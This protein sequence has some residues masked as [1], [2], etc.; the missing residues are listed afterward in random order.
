MVVPV[1]NV[2][3]YLSACVDSLLSQTYEIIE[4][5]LVN[6]GSTDESSEI[7]DAY[8]RSSQRI[9]AVH[10]ENGG[11]SAARNTG[12][13]RATGDYV[14]F[15]DSD[16]WIEADAVRSLLATAQVENADVVVCGFH[17]DVH[18][19]NG[20]LVASTPRLPKPLTV[21]GPLE[22]LSRANRELVGFAGYAWNKLYRR[23]LIEGSTFPEGISLVEDIVFNGPVLARARRVLFI[24]E[25]FVHYVQRPRVT[26]GTGFQPQFGSL[27]ASAGDSVR[28]LLASWGIRGEQADRVVLEVSHGRIQ[29]ALRGLVVNGAVEARIRRAQ[30]KVILKDH[31]VQ[32]ALTAAIGAGIPT[33]VMRP[34]VWSQTRGL[35]W[36][37]YLV[38][39]LRRR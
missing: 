20:E 21:D 2:A 31:L 26:L 6:D 30:M 7:C 12:L 27:V 15:L 39:A 38:H 9:T 33:R 4:I 23:D 22:D 10:R 3:Q 16:D 25:H 37:T 29:W 1:Y 35:T 13:R 24:D 28:G 17:L 8:A 18:D 5:V 11:L 14:L 34:I 36:P 32:D 19:E